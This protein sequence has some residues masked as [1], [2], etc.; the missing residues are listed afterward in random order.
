[1]SLTPLYM[2]AVIANV[3]APNNMLE[4]SAKSGFSFWSSTGLVSILALGGNFQATVKNPVGHTR[5]VF[6]HK[7]IVYSSVASVYA[8]FYYNPTTNIPTTAK[9]VHNQRLNSGIT[10]PV[11]VKSDLLG[12]APTGGT[13]T[14]ILLG[15]QSLNHISYD[16]TIVLVPGQMI[17]INMPFTGIAQALMSFVW[18]EYT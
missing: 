8:R 2:P 16:L 9:A 13:D 3:Q 5:N 7:A 15:L 14:S 18:V 10:T 1:M 17:G 4:Y 11:E 6:L 12:N